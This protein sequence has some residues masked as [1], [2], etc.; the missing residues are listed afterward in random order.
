MK[1]KILQINTVYGTGSTG[2]IVKDIGQLIEKNN[3]ESYI[4]Y[5]YGKSSEKN[6]IKIGTTLEYYIH[7]ILSRIT[8]RQG[9]FSYLATKRFLKKVDKIK[10][11]IIHLH[12]IH[13][14]Y[15]NYPL[16]FKYIKKNQI[17]TIWTL[18][19]CWSYTGKCVYYD[20]AQCNKW[21]EKCKNCKQLREY[22][23]S[24]FFDPSEKEYKKKKNI[25]MSVANMHIVTPSKWLAKEVKESYLG[26]N[27][28][29]VI[30]NGI[31]LNQFKKIDSDF[32]ERYNLEKKFIVLGVASEWSRRKGANTF[33]ELSK[34][35]DES[36]KIVMVGLT[37]KQKKDFPSN[38]I[39]ISKTN[40]IKELAEIYSCAD[41]FV[42][43]TLE[44]N[45]PTTNLEALACG[46][47]IVTYNT[48][49][50]IEAVNNNCGIIVEK[51]KI[52]ELVKAIK[53]VR[54][55]NMFDSKI[56]I[57]ES[58]KYDKWKNFEKYITLY[59]EI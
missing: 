9:R 49:G 8:G 24:Y 38:I 57:N 1:K 10:P 45:F 54:K 17:P 35:L 28:I 16:L 6:T 42:N 21:K 39:K 36:Y 26:K 20:Y 46:T 50:S 14:N 30:P 44:D 32:R 34:L 52:S 53:N 2:R 29:Q 51:E 23:I 27:H 5:G 13:G 33:I 37:E 22:P 7:N 15:I 31:D 12:N 48:G 11:D 59:E 18:H 58:K 55:S 40:S 4:A 19:D 47:P 43:P 25:F 3:M 41:V 56:C